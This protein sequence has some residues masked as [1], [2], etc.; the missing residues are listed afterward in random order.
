LNVSDA[1][2]APACRRT[3]EGAQ[4]LSPV[5]HHRI[6]TNGI[7]LH[8]VQAGPQDGPLA[9][10]LHGFPEFWMGWSHQVDSLVQAGYR[11]WI[12]DQRGYN[13]SDKPTDIASYR[14]D[15]VADD[16]CGLITASGRERA[17]VCGHDWGGVAAWRLANKYPEKVSRLVIANSPHFAVMMRHIKSS[18]TQL[19]KSWYMFFFQLPKLPEHGLSRNN[20]RALVGVLRGTSR[21]GSF[22]NA[23][24][25][26]YRSAWQQ[27]GAISGMLN[28]YRAAFRAQRGAGGSPRITVP[29]LL[30][31]GTKDHALET[32]IA[33]KSIALCDAGELLLIEEAGHWL[34]HEEPERINAAIRD[35]LAKPR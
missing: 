18:V 33:H 16:I 28:W 23:D 8:V 32:A 7:T 10:L 27:P 24:I 14:L 3:L 26:S 2:L 12:P 29:T 22:S 31:W 19:M 17:V 4:V 11:V 6:Q 34:L 1:S 15:A 20:Y 5:E 35:F 30:I 9:I 13:T 21:R 25:D